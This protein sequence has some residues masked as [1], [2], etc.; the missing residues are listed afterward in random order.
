[1]IRSFALIAMLRERG[2][3]WSATFTSLEYMSLA[4]LFAQLPC[5]F[6]IKSVGTPASSS[7][8]RFARDPLAAPNLGACDELQAHRREL[9]EPPLAPVPW[10]PEALSSHPT[11][12]G[13]T[14]SLR[15]RCHCRQLVLSA[16]LTSD[17]PFGGESRTPR[18]G[19]QPLRHTFRGS[20]GSR[21]VARER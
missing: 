14:H 15:A 17:Q 8:T 19:K 12:F 11:Y 4:K 6:N 16:C 21:C 7:N 3:S 9:H 2:A 5:L 1:M 13:W 20:S 10:D 18:V